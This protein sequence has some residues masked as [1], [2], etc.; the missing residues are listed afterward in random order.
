MGGR[1]HTLGRGCFLTQVGYGAR[2]ATRQI[3]PSST[4]M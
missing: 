4:A 3:S 2:G 1:L